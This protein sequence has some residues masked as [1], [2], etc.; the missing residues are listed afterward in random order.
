MNSK[1]LFHEGCKPSGVWY[2]GECKSVHNCEAMATCCCDPRCQECN[3][4]C[5]RGWTL[6]D[7]CRAKADDVKERERFDK[8][9][10]VTDYKGWVFLEDY[11]YNGGFFESV[12][13]LLDFCTDKDETGVSHRVP[14]YCWACNANHFVKIDSGD[15]TERI[16]DNAYE[17]WDPDDLAGLPELH[18]A[19]KAF[20]DANKDVVAYF[21]DYKKAVLLAAVT[22]T[23]A[24]KQA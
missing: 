18:A 24:L 22:K 23:E 19:L 17:D 12:E 16:A 2:C 14:E 9:E 7:K 5:G 3:E 4:P 10:K 11:G 20:E 15:I 13:E 6:C 21:P 8:A 1:Q